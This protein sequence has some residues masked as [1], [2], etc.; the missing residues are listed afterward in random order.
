[1]H[2][3]GIFHNNLAIGVELMELTDMLVLRKNLFGPK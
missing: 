2:A 3:K 1:M